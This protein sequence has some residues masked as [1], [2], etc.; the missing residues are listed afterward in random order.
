MVA[1]V[2]ALL[3]GVG[4]GWAGWGLLCDVSWMA[5]L[6]KQLKVSM[7]RQKDQTLRKT[8]YGALGVPWPAVVLKHF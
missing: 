4:F 5:I 6:E 1:A 7:S 8:I 2:E 3:L